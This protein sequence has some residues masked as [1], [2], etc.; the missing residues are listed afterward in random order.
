ML[1]SFSPQNLREPPNYPEE[2]GRFLHTS[3]YQSRLLITIVSE[4]RFSVLGS[5]PQRALNES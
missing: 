3:L 5:P 1:L 2:F 4:K